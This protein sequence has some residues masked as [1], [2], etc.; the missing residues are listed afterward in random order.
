MPSARGVQDPGCAGDTA[1][2]LVG[3]WFCL[4]AMSG[5]LSVEKVASHYLSSFPQLLSNG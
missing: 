4:S 2:P 1:S 3:T 5:A